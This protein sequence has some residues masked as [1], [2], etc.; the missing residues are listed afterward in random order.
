MAH[1]PGRYIKYKKIDYDSEIFACLNLPFYVGGYSLGM[2][3]WLFK[4]YRPLPL[5]IQPPSIGVFSLLEIIDSKFIKDNAKS[6]AMDFIRALY[7]AYYGKNTAL[8][9]REWVQTG[10]KDKFSFNDRSTWL[11][12]DYKLALFSDKIHADK[13]SVDEISAFRKFLIENTFAGYEMIPDSGG[14]SYLPY[15]FGA[16]TLASVST[17]AGKLDI[18]YEEIIWNVPLCLCGHISAC[19]AKRNGVKGVERPKDK[20]DIKLQFKLANEREKAGELHPW[21]IAEPDNANFALSE[22]QMKARPEIKKEF[23]AILKA[24]LRAKRIKVQ[25]AK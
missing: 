13:I 15:L 2:W 23:T 5:E 11:K 19:E 7:I 20:A 16:E 10:G 24:Y 12:W 14:G 3:H 25:E 4:N 1:V 17:L 9:V 6:N 8:E 22:M 18:P 21:Q